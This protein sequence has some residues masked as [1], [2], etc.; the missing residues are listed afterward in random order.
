MDEQRRPTTGND[1]QH[2]E[3]TT[4]TGT[5][6][7]CVVVGVLALDESGDTV[8]TRVGCIFSSVEATAVAAD[9]P[10]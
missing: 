2:R 8:G 5:A 10:M 6:R 7:A 3:D 4:P 1:E 9:A